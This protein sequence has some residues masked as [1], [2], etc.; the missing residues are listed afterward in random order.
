MALAV[1]AV[2]VTGFAL[3]RAWLR[4]C[5]HPGLYRH[6]NVILLSVDTLRPD[7]LGCYGYGRATSPNIDAFRK[8]S[9]LFTTAISQAPS[10]LP[11]HASIMTSLIPP[12]HGACFSMKRG[13]ADKRITLAEVL[14]TRGYRT[15]SY[16]GGAQLAPQYGMDQGFEIYDEVDTFPEILERSAE[17]IRAHR[18]ERFFMF[19]HT[20]DTHAPYAPPPE[21]MARFETNGA[22]PLSVKPQEH[23]GQNREELSETAKAHMIAAYDAEIYCMDQTFG[24]LL[25]FIEEQGLADNTIFVLTADHGE[26]F[27]EH[28]TWGWHSHSLYDEL[29]RV[30]LLMR[31]PDRRHAGGVVEQQVRSMDIAPTVLDL[32]GISAPLEFAGES[33]IL[34]IEGRKEPPLVAF[35]A[36]D[37]VRKRARASLR[38]KEWKLHGSRLFDLVNDPGETNDVARDNPAIVALLSRKRDDLFAGRIAPSDA[39]AVKLDKHTEKKLRSL[40]Y[41]R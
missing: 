39:P 2:A 33:L 37:G 31:F 40:G 3:Q 22:G 36:Q 24:K 17:W 10:T 38:T 7:H 6:A 19:L 11:S 27:G 20:I 32:L 23:T 18:R 1:G 14:R 34:R 26:E 13:L 41:I 30:P 15:V 4:R 8:N 9:I 21:C 28:G 29:L 12:H 16:N 5:D 25:R 35:S